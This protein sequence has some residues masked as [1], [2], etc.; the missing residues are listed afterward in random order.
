M[1]L[2]LRVPAQHQKTVVKYLLSIGALFSLVAV[3]LLMAF[4]EESETSGHLWWKTSRQVPYEE[5]LPYLLGGIALVALAVT[6]FAAAAWI[7]IHPKARGQRAEHR[8][9]AEKR[10]FQTQT[11]EGRAQRAFE[12][13]DRGFAVTL[14]IDDGS[15]WPTLREVELQG[16]RQTEMRLRKAVT[17]T[18]VTPH[19]D[20]GH[21]VVRN[22]TQEATFYLR[23]LT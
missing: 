9:L 11:N 23:G 16:W 3:L 10:A 14:R 21:T 15:H 5:R 8:K 6:L 7:A 22:S 2:L 17:T 4:G 20:G 13:G 1:H 18:D 12:R 19:S